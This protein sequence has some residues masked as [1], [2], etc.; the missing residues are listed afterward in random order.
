MT[1]L[2]NI[3]VKKADGTTDITYTAI[4]PAGS[5]T[6]ASW[7]ALTVGSAIAHQPKFTFLGKPN[8]TRT[9]MR[10]KSTFNYPEIATNSTTG[11]TSVVNVV[12]ISGE[13]VI[14]LNVASLVSKE[15]VHQYANLIASAMVK[16]ILETCSNAN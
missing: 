11:L 1:Q 8:A 6:P 2:A 7:R 13:W 16:S 9:V 12:P 10:F 14:P 15:A 4:D 3:T 5:D